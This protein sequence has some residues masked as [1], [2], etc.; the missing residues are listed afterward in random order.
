M[1]LKKY[2]KAA[3]ETRNVILL[4]AIAIIS[5]ITQFLPFAFIGLAG[6][7]YFI[8]QTFKS[9]AFQKKLML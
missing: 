8:L 4:I 2:L 6:Y 5:V 3:S 1:S 9:E 7:I